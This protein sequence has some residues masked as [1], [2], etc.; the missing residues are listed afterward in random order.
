[1]T[2][3]QDWRHNIY[4]ILIEPREPGNIGASARAIKN[5]G[6]RNLELVNPA[7]YQ[8]D[9]A[10]WFARNSQEVLENAKVYATFDEAVAEKGLVVG[11]TRRKGKSRGFI[12]PVRE[13]APKIAGFA[14]ENKV[15]VVFG[16]EDTGLV[17][18]EIKKCGY[19]VNVPTR[20]EQPSLNLGQAVLLVAH[21]LSLLPG[22]DDTE[23]LVGMNEVLPFLDRVENIVRNLG[24]ASRGSR[25]IEES[26]MK[27]IRRII[28]RAGLTD[29]ELNMLRGL[30]TKVE[31]FIE[32]DRK[33]EKKKDQ[34]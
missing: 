9:E 34:P 32:R 16:R 14:A 27:N 22:T 7:D 15:A 3:H 19:V 17:N 28:G 21:E 25:D 10:R 26:I 5:M 2:K 20:E 8:S 23:L 31:G 29:W 1:M 30:A 4:F 18:E 13:C 12:V 6:F 11:T 24:Y 33:R